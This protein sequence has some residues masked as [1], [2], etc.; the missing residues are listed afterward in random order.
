[1]YPYYAD[2]LPLLDHPFVHVRWPGEDNAARDHLVEDF[3]SQL[4]SHSPGVGGFRTRDG[5]LPKSSDADWLRGLSGLYDSPRVVPSSVGHKGALD[6]GDKADRAMAAAQWTSANKVYREGRPSVSLKLLFDIS[7]SMATPLGGGEPRLFRAQEIARS[8]LQSAGDDD[9]IQVSEFSTG[10][11]VRLDVGANDGYPP[12]DRDV[13]REKVQNER[14]NG[15]DQALVAAIGDAAK[16]AGD[17]DDLVVLTDGQLA[18]NNPNAA[19]AAAALRKAHPH[20]RVH[21]VLTG[22]KNCGDD[23][24]KQIVGALGPHAC[25]DGSM[26]PPDDTADAVLAAVLW[27]GGK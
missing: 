25:V 19:A 18:S 22:P 24:I 3:R 1:M 4:G 2:D 13:L 10:A 27:G 17:S 21:I 16:Q 20:L 15:S 5:E 6:A 9:K 26:N 14:A 7:G 23:L 12:G 11:Q 8:V